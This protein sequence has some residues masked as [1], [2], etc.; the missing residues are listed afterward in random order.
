MTTKRILLL[1]L[2]ASCFIH[3]GVQANDILA[4]IENYTA[5][6]A[7]NEIK[8]DGDLEEWPSDEE[9]VITNP[10]FYI[11]KGEGDQ[12]DRVTHEEH[13]GGVW[14][15]LEDHSATIRILYDDENV[16]LGIVV[17]D[18]YH[19]NPG[20]GWNGDS[21]QLHIA[22]EDRASRVGLH[23][24]ALPAED[25]VDE[26]IEDFVIHNE[27]SLEGTEVFIIRDSAA[28]T[29][30]Y[31]IMLPLEV[32]GVDELAEGVKFGLGMAINDGDEDTPGQKGW[33][34]WGPHS[35]VH[36]K[37]PEETGLV[38]LGGDAPRSGLGF[39]IRTITKAGNQAEITWLSK[40]ST[41]YT[42]E[43]S[44]DFKQFLEL[45]DGHP[46]DGEETT[47]IDEEATEPEAY[48]RLIE[49]D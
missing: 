30:T 38:T 24:I 35:V 34:G 42:I 26:P 19:Q 13:G 10:P 40:K 36:G 33:S 4:D 29:T 20:D 18:D 39:A 8:L 16:Y 28:K 12:G 32:V 25:P 22:D 23:N 15:G 37:S 1:P 21:I 48:Y 11:P 14:D 45:T 47:F 17:T 49:E 3:F 9:L 31:E 5:F 2:A 6:K 41:S 27:G 46:S 43:K 7:P 44:T